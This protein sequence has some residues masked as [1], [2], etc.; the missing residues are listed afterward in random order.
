MLFL[1]VASGFLEIFSYGI[2]GIFSK[3]PELLEV[4]VRAM[5]ILLSTMMF[6]GPTVMFITAFQGLSRGMMALVLSL[7]RQFLLFVPLLYGMSYLF[8]LYGIWLALPVSDLISFALTFAF[9]FR[10]YKKHRKID[11]WFGSSPDSVP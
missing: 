4:A 9:T 1:A 2:I 3:D 10:E 11:D 8:G 7:A 5:R 6:V